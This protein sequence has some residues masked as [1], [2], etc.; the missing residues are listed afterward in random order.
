MM[1]QGD[2]LINL[3]YKPKAYA[4]TLF[5]AGTVGLAVWQIW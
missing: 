1:W 2:P 3:S 4:L 5:Y